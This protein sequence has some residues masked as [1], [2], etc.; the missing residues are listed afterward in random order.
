VTESSPTSEMTYREATLIRIFDA[1]R[2][3]VWKAWTEPEQI[4]VW[5]GPQGMSTPLSSIEM[6][7]RPGGVFRLT[8]VSDANGKEF[9]SDMVYREVV[10]PEL[11]VFGWDAQRGLGPGTVTITFTDLGE[12]TELTNHFAGFATDQVAGGAKIG[13][14]QQLDKLVRHLSA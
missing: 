14:S 8:M 10:E 3:V 12:R 2:E 13:T 11:L 6:D 1:P 5:W 9:P 4:A 7:V